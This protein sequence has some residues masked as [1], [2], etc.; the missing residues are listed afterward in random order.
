MPQS[1][2]PRYPVW[3]KATGV[4]HDAHP[5]LIPPRAANAL[6]A[7]LF[8]GLSVLFYNTHGA[9][10]F[11]IAL[12]F[13]RLAALDLATYTLPNIYTLPLL[14]V[15]VAHAAT[16]GLLM[17]SLLACLMLLCILWLTIQLGNRLGLGSG[18]LKL[19]AALF[20]F[21]P[22]DAALFALGAGSLLWLPVGFAFPRRAVPFGVPI[23]LGWV[24][25]L[26][27]PGLPNAFFSTIP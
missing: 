2:T 24:L 10:G 21:F 14:A 3:E 11:L 12:L 1:P 9:T 18:D 7:V 15:G 27:F 23:L 5:G 19:I 4:A 16:H 26:R 22:A 20:A 6:T 25:L 17:Q 8:L 13:A